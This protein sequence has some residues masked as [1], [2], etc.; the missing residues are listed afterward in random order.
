[1][2]RCQRGAGKRFMTVEENFAP[3]DLRKAIDSI[4]GELFVGEGLENLM[5]R[6]SPVLVEVKAKKIDGTLLKDTFTPALPEKGKIFGQ[7]SRV[8][9]EAEAIRL[10]REIGLSQ[11]EIAQRLDRSQAW[12]SGVVR[13]GKI[14]LR[15]KTSKRESK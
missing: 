2:A 3:E 1:M 12:V 9:R 15:E 14:N 5:I 13:R 4:I 8:S 7:V 11:V 6:A 10:Y